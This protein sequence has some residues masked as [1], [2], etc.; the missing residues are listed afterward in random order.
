[1]YV[2]LFDNFHF[3]ENEEN[4]NG[5][6]KSSIYHGF[7][8]TSIWREN[9]N[10]NKIHEITISYVL[11]GFWHFDFTRN[12][13]NSTVI[14]NRQITNLTRQNC[15]KSKLK[16]NSW[17]D[18][19]DLL[20]AC[21]QLWINEKNMKNQTTKNSSKHNGFTNNLNFTRKNPKIE[22]FQEK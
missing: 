7:V 22:R 1:M 20:L 12:Y 4:S 10:P 17:N 15:K 2:L 16:S 3:T 13:K 19:I 6:K 21:W 14:K 18:N 5:I 8:T 11:L 9:P